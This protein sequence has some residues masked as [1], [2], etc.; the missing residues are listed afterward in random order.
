MLTSTTSVRTKCSPHSS[1]DDPYSLS[2][3]AIY[4]LCE[5]RE[6]G[7]WVGSYFGGVDYYPKSYTYFEKY[8]PKDGE[9]TL[10]GKRV[11]EFCQDNKGTL[12]IGTEDGG[13]NRFDPKTKTFSSLLPG[14]R[15][16]ID[17]G[18]F[19][20]CQTATGDVYLGTMFGLLKYNP[21]TDDF[22]RIEELAGRFVYDIKEDSGGNLWLAT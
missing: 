13:L 20:I 21:Q 16:L 10:R 14:P 4:S 18:V 8:Y 11:R 9:N 6:H 1:Q 12:W 17:N 2:D 19:A 3:N 22:D 5:D 7:I 15:S